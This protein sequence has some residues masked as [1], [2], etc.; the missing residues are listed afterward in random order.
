M[1]EQQSQHPPLG[2]LVHCVL[3]EKQKEEQKTASF[4]AL[5]SRVQDFFKT[6][7][8]SPV[9]EWEQYDFLSCEVR[10]ENNQLVAYGPLPPY[11]FVHQK[12]TFRPG[13]AWSYLFSRGFSV[14]LPGFFF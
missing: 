12:Q 8:T 11:D 2:L 14:D 9:Q 6:R 1:F 7:P 13:H 3:H 4:K 10:M 5:Q